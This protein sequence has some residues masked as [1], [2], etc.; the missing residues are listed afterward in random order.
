M[1]VLAPRHSVQI[2]AAVSAVLRALPLYVPV[3][4]SATPAAPSQATSAATLSA[5]IP[6]QPLA[7]ALAALATQTGLQMVYVSEVVHSLSSRAVPAGLSAQDALARLLQGTGLQFEFLTDR[8]VRILPAP[9]PV[10]TMP[11]LSEEAPQEVIVTANRREENAQDVAL[12]I[13]TL[14]GEQ[15][16]Q[17]RVTTFSD[18]LQYAPNVTF[19]GNGPGT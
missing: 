4:L 12:T 6:A 9:R 8:T 15:L 19:S 14:N 3:A 17:L 5:D 1:G 10:M 13:Q 2:A 16:S 7:Q 18:L 11:L